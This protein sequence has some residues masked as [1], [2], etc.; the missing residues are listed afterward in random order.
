[1]LRNAHLATLCA[2]GVALLAGPFVSGIPGGGAPLSA[3]PVPFGAH[4]AGEGDSQ[5]LSVQLRPPALEPDEVGPDP[6]LLTPDSRISRVV[7]ERMDRDLEAMAHFRPG[8]AFWRHIFTIPDGSVVFGSGRDGR[9][10]AVFPA[11]GDW[12]RTGRWEE[13]SLERALD[14]YRLEGR[15][16]TRRDQV[17]EILEARLGEPVVHNATRGRFLLPN[18]RRYGSFIAEWGEIYQRF[19][20]PAEVGLAQAILESGLNGT[21]RSEARAIG[22][23]QWL[24]ANWDRMKRLSPHEIEGHNQT[25]QA[26]YCAAYL[27]VLATKFGSFIPAL[28]EH[29]AGGTNVGRTII[30]GERLG[31][32]DIREQYLVGAD[33]ARD[34]RTI[35]N[36]RFRPLVR[37]YGP[38]SFL[39]SEMV[40]GNA[41]NVVNLRESIHQE[42]IHAMRATRPITIE[43]VAQRTGLSLDEIRRYNPALIRRVPAGAALYLPVHVPEFGPDVAF[44]HREAPEGFSTV[45]AD[46]LQ[47]EADPETWE[48]PSFGPVLREFRDRFRATESEEGTVMATVLGYVAGEM[49]TGRRAE[50]LREFRT[51]PAI[52]RLV[53][54]GIRARNGGQGAGIL[55]GA[56]R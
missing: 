47:L 25:T 46:F 48:D 39:Y 53:Q 52:E 6:S 54:E 28:S 4:V 32:E 1:M 14:G 10:L 29:H 19:G 27:T 42:R 12:H 9:M 34:L 45:L 37:S 35:S 31:G 8:Y 33:F 26:A 20:V 13:P 41:Q 51:D 55:T 3:V 30:K 40:F 22:F 24:P 50:I 23:C 44:W 7:G 11:Q 56:T 38:R 17:A 36:Q 15:L 43:E 16:G 2:T 49:H 21:I 18:A 5:D